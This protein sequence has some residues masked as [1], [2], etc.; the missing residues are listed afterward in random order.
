MQEKLQELN[1]LMKASPHKIHYVL[2]KAKG[3]GMMMSIASPEKKVGS[4]PCSSSSSCRTVRF[5]APLKLQGGG[6]FD[7]SPCM[8]PSVQGVLDFQGEDV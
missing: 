7:T 6:S 1:E 8:P 5:R 4:A 3:N 2:E